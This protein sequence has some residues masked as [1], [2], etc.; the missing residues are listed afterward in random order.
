MATVLALNAEFDQRAAVHAAQL[1]WIASPAAGVE[2]KMLDRIGG[3]VARATSLVR[4]APHS[5]FARHTHGGGEEFLV[6]EGTFQDE[7]GDYPPG[8]YVRNPPTSAHTPGSTD[9]CTILVKLW[10]FD[11]TDREPVRIDTARGSFL[12]VPG[13]PGV[14]SQPLYRGFAETVALERWDGGA[15][16]RLPAA[17]GIELLVLDGELHNDGERF[18]RHSWLRLPAAT[19]L[20]ARAGADGCRLWLKHGHLA[21]LSAQA[22][23]TRLA[24]AAG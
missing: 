2:R 14:S 8:Y 20:S 13:R 18:G 22:V 21:G 3:E 1:E 15:E 17:G 6:L 11:P 23:R 7:L 24:A 4:Y 16:V 12:P 10:Q 5:H 19:P 9:G